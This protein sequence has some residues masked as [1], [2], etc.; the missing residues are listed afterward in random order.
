MILFA[1]PFVFGSAREANP[2]RRV[3]LG[4][5]V[6]IAYYYFEQSLGY[7]GLLLGLHPAFTSLM[8]LAIIA[9][10]AKW[11]MLRVP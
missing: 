9:L 3:T 4:T 2:G 1:L 11:F 7:M 10:L 5:I 8:P 6:G